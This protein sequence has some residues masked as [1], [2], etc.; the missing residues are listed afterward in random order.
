MMKKVLC[1]GVPIILRPPI[2]ARL[3]TVLLFMRAKSECPIEHFYL[4]KKHFVQLIRTCADSLLANS[5]GTVSLCKLP[6]TLI[7]LKK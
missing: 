2:D 5:D 6:S 3:L 7:A 1:P 4:N